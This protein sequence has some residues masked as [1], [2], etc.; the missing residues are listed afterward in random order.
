MSTPCCLPLVFDTNSTSLAIAHGNQSCDYAKLSLQFW[1][2]LGKNHNFDLKNLYSIKL[3]KNYQEVHSEILHLMI[4]MTV[5]AR[6]LSALSSSAS[7]VFDI[8]AL[9]KSDYYYYYYNDDN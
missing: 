2:Y 6:V 3:F 5:L 9:Y 4:T 1:F 7:E 8:L